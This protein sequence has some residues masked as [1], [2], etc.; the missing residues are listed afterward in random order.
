MYEGQIAVVPVF[1]TNGPTSRLLN[2]LK[3]VTLG[4]GDDA[5]DLTGSQRIGAVAAVVRRFA[6]LPA[7]FHWLRMTDAAV[8][9]L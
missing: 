7:V 4:A 2:R 8:E 6:A 3:E 5:G 1:W 9:G